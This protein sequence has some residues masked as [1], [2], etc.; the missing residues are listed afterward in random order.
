MLLERQVTR[1]A[2]N[3]FQMATFYVPNPLAALFQAWVCGRSLPGIAVSIPVADFDISCG[4]C[5][6]AG[7]GLSESSKLFLPCVARV[8]KWSRKLKSEEAYTL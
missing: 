7:R 5:V 2:V 3:V 6:F 1:I 8:A 4:C